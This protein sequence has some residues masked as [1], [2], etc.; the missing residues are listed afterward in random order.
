MS[1]RHPTFD[2][3]ASSPL[4]AEFPLSVTVRG[5]LA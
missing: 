2:P 4:V 5:N 1:N 3:V